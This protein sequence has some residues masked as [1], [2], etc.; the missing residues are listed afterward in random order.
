MTNHLDEQVNAFRN[1]FLDAGPY[2][3]VW[4]DALTQKVRESGRITVVH[5]LIAVVVNP[6]GRRGILGLD[7]A[8]A[9]DGAGWPCCAR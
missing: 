7:V 4:A 9:E 2:A 1:Q 5:T 3:F 6:D 8:K